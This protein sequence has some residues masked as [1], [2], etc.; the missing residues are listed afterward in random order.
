[1]PRPDLTL[2][3]G[4]PNACAPCH[5]DRAAKWLADAATKWWG[6]KRSGRPHYGTALHA[7]NRNL[8]GAAALLVM[9]LDDPSQ[10]GIVRASA[11]GLLGDLGE[12]R[13]GAPLERALRD[14]DPLVRDAA[15]NALREFDAG[16]RARLLAALLTDPVRT[17][18]I[19]AGR[20]LATVPPSLLQPEAQTAA[21][22]A[23]AEWR[24]EQAVND[25][26]AEA[27]LT[28][29]A[30]HAERGEFADA[31]REYRIALRLSPRFPP[32][33]LNLADLYRQ[34]DRDQE[35]ERIL[36]D[37]L[38]M[39]PGDPRLL[40]AL[41][42]LL[43]RRQRLPEALSALEKAAVAAP[44]VARYAY[45]Y[46]V[47]LHAA[48]RIDRAMSVLKQAHQRH[49]G[50]ADILVALATISRDAGRL[51]DA[52]DYAGRLVALDPDDQQ[53][54]QLLAQLQAARR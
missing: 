28:L 45:V 8:P 32:T 39:A 38:R 48:G 35:G 30:L 5:K 53:A 12:S 43:V 6:T 22:R 11:A 42:L 52:I 49:P 3:I 46:G 27:H 31:E 18:R 41:G 24:A 17:V 51:D 21:T 9:V 1:V 44:D 47:A 33:Y 50:D 13:R 15:V 7:G 16:T 14:P 36:R 2:S 54:R 25:D 10:A 23:L 26:R 37:G 40:H 20:G 29:G 4:A 19:D 34:Q